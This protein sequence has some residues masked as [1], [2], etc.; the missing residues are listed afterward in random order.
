[1]AEENMHT[2]AQVSIGGIVLGP[3]ALDPRTATYLEEQTRL[4]RL[5][6]DNLIE[7]NAFEISHLRF[8]RFSDYAKFALEI[9]IGLVV[10]LVVCGLGTMVWN[11][12]QDGDLVVDA[13]QIPQDVAATGLTGTVL[14]GRVLDSF[15]N[16]QDETFG[17]TQGAGSYHANL[18]DAVRVEIPSTGISI[19]ELNR[20][21]RLWLGHETH[22]TGDLVHTPAGF[23]LTTRFGA[24][25]GVTIEDKSENLDVLVKKSAEHIYAAALPYRYVEY[26]VKKRRFAEAS[27]LAPQLAVQGTAKERAL[28]NS[29]WAKVY[30]FE[31]DMQRSLEKG[32][33]AVTLDPNNPVTHAWLSVGEADF[34][35]TEAARENSDAAVREWQGG[36]AA[37][38]S[39]RMALT[40]FLFTAYRD[41]LTGDFAGANAAWARFFAKDQGSNGNRQNAASD[42]ASTHD[43]R[44]A[45]HIASTITEKDTHG[46]PDDQLPWARMD[47]AWSA[48]D[49][50]ETVTQ[51]RMADAILRSQADNAWNGLLM[52]PEW[53][54]A[55][56]RTGDFRGADSVIAKTTQDCDDCLL[57]RGR[58]AALEGRPDE[59][60]Q[61]FSMVAARSPHEPFAETYWGEMLLHKGD[62]DGAVVK[63]EIAHQK[64]PHFA[65][66]LEMWGEALIAKNRSDLALAKFEEANKYAPNWSRLHEKWG[67][68]LTYLNRKDEAAKQ[69][70]LVRSLNG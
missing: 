59:A 5:Q 2:S 28:A 12:T 30:F 53:A 64:G 63:F 32:R 57:Q 50:T 31:G 58:I 68:A 7:Q 42:A 11:A 9:S 20:Y 23:A 18:P 51:A 56:A 33:D 65:D 3:G 67:E 29:A 13:F 35:H 39:G 16:M 26:L 15:G 1:M 52:W 69:F 27:V 6:S 10:L 25:P 61:D 24:Q 60:A 66:P 17:T 8:R 44:A 21:L 48:E 36:S 70:A 37:F 46:R 62:L 41:E 54:Y 19:G 38:T 49:W 55:L 43:L 34:G 14:A 4:A 47:I 45:R 40:P 22:V